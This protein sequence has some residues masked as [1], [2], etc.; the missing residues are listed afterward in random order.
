MR[1]S[2]HAEKVT[3]IK[4]LAW[5]IIKPHI[6]KWLTERALVLPDAKVTELCF[7]AK[8]QKEEVLIANAALA[9]HALDELEK[10]EI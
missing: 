9:S 1:K 8:I 2:R 10:L 6:R 3:M 7:K 5:K 4:S